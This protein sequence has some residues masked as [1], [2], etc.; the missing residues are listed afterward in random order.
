LKAFFFAKTF[1]F[2]IDALKK[3]SEAQYIMRLGWLGSIKFQPYSQILDGPASN[4][5]SI[6][7]NE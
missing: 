2:A 6:N 1:F 3:Q 7:E 4:K 5:I